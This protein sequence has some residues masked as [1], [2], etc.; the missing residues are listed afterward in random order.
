MI[1]DRE[2]SDRE[3]SE[4]EASEEPGS[5]YDDGEMLSGMDEDETG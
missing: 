1:S 4:R 3:T 5:L 2:T